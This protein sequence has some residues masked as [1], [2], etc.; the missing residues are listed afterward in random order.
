MRRLRVA[1]FW[2]DR[3]GRG[4]AQFRDFVSHGQRDEAVLEFDEG[5][6][7]ARGLVRR[8]H[9]RLQH[10]RPLLKLRFALKISSTGGGYNITSFWNLTPWF[11]P[12]HDGAFYHLN[13]DCESS[14]TDRDKWLTF[15]SRADD[16]T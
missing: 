11:P 15:K 8:R 12:R 7:Y 13:L 6:R 2:S 4:A 14:R 16:F 5:A 3:I 10:A 9:H 1:G